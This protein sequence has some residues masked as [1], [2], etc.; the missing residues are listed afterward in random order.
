MVTGTYKPPQASGWGDGVGGWNSNGQGNSQSNWGNQ[1]NAPKKPNP[2]MG[3][4][5][6]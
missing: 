6:M 4:L 3:G 5:L 1:T 2:N